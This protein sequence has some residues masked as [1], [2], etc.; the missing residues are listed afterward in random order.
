LALLGGATAWAGL[1]GVTHDEFTADV[2]ADSGLQ[3]GGQNNSPG[4]AGGDVT[5]TQSNHNNRGGDN[6]IVVNV[7]GG[8]PIWLPPLLDAQRS[9]PGAATGGENNQGGDGNFVFNIGG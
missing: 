9:S 6:N 8:V 7:G 1:T 3:F 4:A 5:G 2:R